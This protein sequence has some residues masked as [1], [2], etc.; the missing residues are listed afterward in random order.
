MIRL[1]VR[2][3]LKKENNGV[4]EL[5]IGVVNSLVM[6]LYRQKTCSIIFFM[7]KKYHVGRNNQDTDSSNASSKMNQ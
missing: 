1:E 5:L 2:K 4:V 7:D 6:I 3:H